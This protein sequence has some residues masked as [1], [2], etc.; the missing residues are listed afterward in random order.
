VRFLSWAKKGG[1]EPDKLVLLI[2]RNLRLV[3]LAIAGWSGPV[4][5]G[6][7]WNSRVSRNGR[8]PTEGGIW[9]EKFE[10]AELKIVREM[11]RC[12]LRSHSI[13]YQSQQSVFGSHEAR[14]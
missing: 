11:I 1:T 4:S 7:L 12:V 10:G 6:S 14:R 5:F 3:S 2:R 13:V 9:A 8:S